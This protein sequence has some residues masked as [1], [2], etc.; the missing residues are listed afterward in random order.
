M[1]NFLVWER[2]PLERTDDDVARHYTEF[3]NTIEDRFARETIE[4]AMT[5]R[6]IIAALRCRRLQRDPPPAPAA[7][8]ARIAR[9][10]SHPDFR[11]GYQF[12]WIATVESQLNGDT[13]FD[14]ERTKLN[15]IWQHAKRLADRCQFTFEAVVLYLIRW[16]VVYRWTRRDARVG[17]EK[18]NQLVS[19]AM[20]RY[21]DMFALPPD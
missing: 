19:E 11:L 10:W 3:M 8:A 20:G 6:T 16:E 7:I 12:P 13:P 1:R 15:I 14:L 9:S 21:A 18:F 5:V 4:H 2:Q 17:Q